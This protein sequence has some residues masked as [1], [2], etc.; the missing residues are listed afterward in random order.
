MVARLLKLNEND[1]N[2]NGGL[3]IKSHCFS[4]K[5]AFPVHGGSLLLSQIIEFFVKWQ[6]SKCDSIETTS[7]RKLNKQDARYRLS[8]ND[9]LYLCCDD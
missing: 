9:S 8:D 2:N 5:F 1:L 6:D 3:V 4:I 7:S